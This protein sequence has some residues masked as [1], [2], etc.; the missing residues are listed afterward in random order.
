MRC[1]P[2]MVLHAADKEMSRTDFLTQ[3]AHL[4]VTDTVHLRNLHIPNFVERVGFFQPFYSVDA[5]SIMKDA[6]L[7]FCGL[8]SFLW[9]CSCK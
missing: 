4:R 3:K 7:F 6:V 2:S 5:V 1:E 9:V 8:F